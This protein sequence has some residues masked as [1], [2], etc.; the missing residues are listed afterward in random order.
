MFDIKGPFIQYLKITLAPRKR[1]QERFKFF[2][3]NI[4][5]LIYTDKY[6]VEAKTANLQILPMQY[7]N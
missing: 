7:N 6:D 5:F 1:G 3:D 2:F 4:V